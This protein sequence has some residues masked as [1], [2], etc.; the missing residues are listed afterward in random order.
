M[1]KPEGI[2]DLAS[3]IADASN[4]PVRPVDGSA[5]VA[6]SRKGTS[7]SVFLRLPS[8]LHATLE[9]EAVNRTKATGKGV[10]VQQ[11]IVSKLAGAA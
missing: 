4:K 3:R 6:K 7:V 10:T 11:I 5:S 2:D 8:D 9:A 1:K